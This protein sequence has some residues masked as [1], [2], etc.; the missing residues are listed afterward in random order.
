[1]VIFLYCITISVIPILLSF[2]PHPKTRAMKHLDNRI[3]TDTLSF[4]ETASYKY[5]KAIYVLSFFIVVAAGYG[6][7]LLKS[8][9]YI[10]DDVTQQSKVMRD[11]KF[12]EREL[13]GIMPLE[14]LIDT[15]KKGGALQMGTLKKMDALQDS[16]YAHPMFS[17]PMSAVNGLKF[18]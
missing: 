1:M 8:K 17:K 15:K 6:I 16:L 3:M 5:R 18:A 14:I 4:F 12:F 10:L 7:S 13:K 11:L 9:G 2:L